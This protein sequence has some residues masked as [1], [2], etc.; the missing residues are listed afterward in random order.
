ML[1]G[2]S[3]DAVQA[4]EKTLELLELLANCKERLSICEIADKLCLNRREVLFMLVTLETRELVRWDDVARVY[5]PGQTA[6]EFAKSFRR[7]APSLPA[8]GAGRTR[9][10]LPGKHTPRPDRRLAT[11]AMA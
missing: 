6:L 7:P 10:A 11:G 2:K 4:M 8:K 1:K 3:L 9:S 5:R